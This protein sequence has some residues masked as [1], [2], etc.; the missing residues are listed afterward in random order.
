VMSAEPRLAHRHPVQGRRIA[1]LRRAWHVVR[2][3]KPVRSFFRN[4]QPV[5]TLV[6]SRPLLRL[7]RRVLRGP[8]RQGR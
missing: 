2:D 7:G 6:R 3:H 5:R 4:R 1:P 8:C